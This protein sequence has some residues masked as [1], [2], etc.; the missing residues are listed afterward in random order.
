MT[1]STS[2]ISLDAKL[3][4]IAETK[5]VSDAFAGLRLLSNVSMPGTVKLISGF[6]ETG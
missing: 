2:A 5:S 6:E 1:Q 4:I 3:R